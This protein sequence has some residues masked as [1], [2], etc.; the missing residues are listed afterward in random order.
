M[1]TNVKNNQF[2]DKYKCI[3]ETIL[4]AAGNF[5]I[6]LQ[7]INPVSQAKIFFFFRLLPI[8][9]SKFSCSTNMIN[10]YILKVIV[11]SLPFIANFL[12]NTTKKFLLKV[13]FYNI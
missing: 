8:L 9:M 11:L 12:L 10:Q 2:A 13:I 5:V 6:F 1:D 3:F 4:F 7:S